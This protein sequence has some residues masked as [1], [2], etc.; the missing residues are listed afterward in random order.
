MCQT[1]Q[2][3]GQLHANRNAEVS[4]ILQID[5]Q[6]EYDFTYWWKDTF[7]VFLSKHNVSPGFGVRLVRAATCRMCSW[8]AVTTEVLVLKMEWLSCAMYGM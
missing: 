3:W 4:Y 7:C 1:T 8:V 5:S 6:Y 2:P